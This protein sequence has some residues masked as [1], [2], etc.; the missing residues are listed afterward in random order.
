[1]EGG[2]RR[3]SKPN[4]LG[5]AMHPRWHLAAHTIWPCGLGCQWLG[6]YCTAC[7]NYNSV[8]GYITLGRVISCS[9]PFLCGL[10]EDNSSKPF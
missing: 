1:M 10:G 9:D 4:C 7:T 8:Y 6:L 3:V 5:T 2:T